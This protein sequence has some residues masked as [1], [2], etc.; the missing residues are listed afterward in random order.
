MVAIS[1]VAG[2]FTDNRFVSGVSTAGIAA[3]A[4]VALVLGLPRGASNRFE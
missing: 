3:A 4:P 1:G 2:A